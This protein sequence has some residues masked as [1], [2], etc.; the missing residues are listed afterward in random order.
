MHIGVEKNNDD[1]K[2]HVFSSNGHDVPKHIL[3][4]EAI[5]EELQREEHSVIRKNGSTPSA[6][7]ST[8]KEV[9]SSKGDQKGLGSSHQPVCR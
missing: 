4:A 5:R 1:A 6:S 9:L 7:L 2:R 3:V 8:G